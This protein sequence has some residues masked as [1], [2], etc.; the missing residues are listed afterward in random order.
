MRALDK[1]RLRLRS[2]LRRPT[3][4][5]ELDAEFQF[6]VDQQ[7][8]ENIASGMTRE[9]A[10][11]AAVRTVGGVARFQEECRDMRRMNVVDDLTRDLRYAGRTLRRSPGFAA[12]AVLIMALGIGANT[13]VFSVVNTVLLKPLAYRDPDRIVT[14]SRTS[15]TGEASGPLSRQIAVLDFDAWHDQSSSFEALAYY[16]SDKTPVMPGPTAEYAQ[17]T[18]V[19]PEF[20]R[21]FAA[22]PMLGR[23]FTSEEV[24]K[25]TG[26]A[27]MISHAYWQSRFAR[28]PRVVGQTIRR[29]GSALP[30]VGILPPGF[31]FPDQTDLWIPA[32]TIAADARGYRSQNYLAVGRIKPGATLD[33]VQAEMITIAGRLEQQYPEHYQD[34]SVAVARLHDDLVGDVRLTLYL[35]LGAVTVVLLIA[36][37]NTATLLLGRASARSREVAVRAALGASQ[38]RIVRQLLAESLLLALLAGAA[39]LLLA[40]GGSKAL[41][42]FAPADL[43]RLAETAVD[44]R[45]LVFTLVVSMAATFVFGLVPALYGSKVDLKE[46]LKQGSTRSVVGGGLGRTRGV[47]VVA[48]IA[49]AV[50]LLSGAGL[51]IKSLVALHDVALGFRP[52]NVLVTRAT[53]PGPPPQGTNRFFRPLL[54]QLANLPGVVAAGATMATPGNAESTS[55]TGFYFVDHMP[56]RL[57]ASRDPSAILSI[58][59]PRTFAALGIPL[60]SGRDFNDG[61]TPDA[62]FVAVVNEALARQAFPGENPLGRTIFCTFDSDQ[63]MTIVGVVGSVRQYGPASEPMAECYMPYTQHF[64]N[65]STLSLVVRTVGSPD[66]L[67]ET[68]RRLAHERSPDV[69]L[70]LTTMEGRL[71]QTVAAP[72]FRTLLFGLFAGL[73]VC[74][75]MAGVYG[76]MA[77]TVGQRSSEIGLRMALGASRGSVVRLVVRQGFVSAGIGLAL[78]VA[79]AVAGSRLLTSML[80]HVRP[81]DPQVYLAVAVLLGVVTLCAS[82]VPARRASKI[83]PLAALREE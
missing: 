29:G 37:T 71:S 61:D 10:R 42:A 39:G 16:R 14:L 48:E 51:L 45:V 7:V 44:A 57:D 25:G 12:L 23:S 4:E 22:E 55:S 6:H 13:A 56:S 74:L 72:R 52:E 11:R 59:A 31:Q 33:Q 8:E 40:Y 64:Y 21:V 27:V 15:K 17:A 1:I 83:D 24:Q 32:D 18:V 41:V 47:L 82:Y 63:G 46:T 66:A 30:I 76:V 73:A 20:F 65:M 53:Y 78:G 70:E 35:L 79:A 81:Y 38:R 69:A 67:A 50:V 36:C 34:R 43:P 62:P 75:A 19:S 68:V 58:V 9:E 2:L 77:H 26:G 80:F 3:V 60:T 54:S 49:L 28:D 5:R